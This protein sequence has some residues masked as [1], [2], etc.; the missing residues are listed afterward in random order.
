MFDFNNFFY[1]LRRKS[2]PLVTEGVVSFPRQRP[3][4]TC[5]RAVKF[6]VERNNDRP[7]S[8]R[9]RISHPSPGPTAVKTSCDFPL[10]F[11]QF[12]TTSPPDTLPP[13]RIVLWSVRHSV[14]LSAN[15]FP[16][17]VKSA[18]NGV[19]VGFGRT[20]LFS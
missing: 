19:P 3:D 4:V 18:R 15:V 8:V 11:L 9:S 17:T 12:F 6:R 1:C 10:F 2:P 7:A 16:P 14:S 5:S 20:L 13:P